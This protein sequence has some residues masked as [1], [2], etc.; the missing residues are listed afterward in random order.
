MSPIQFFFLLYSMV[1][2]LHIHV[3]ILFSH[4]KCSIRSDQTEFPV[5]HSRIPLLIH[6]EGNIL[7]LLN[8]SSQYISL[9]PHHLATMSLFSESM[10]FFSVE[11]FICAVYQIPDMSDTILFFFYSSSPTALCTLFLRSALLTYY[12]WALFCLFVYFF[13]VINCYFPNTFFFYCTAW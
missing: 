6:P 8:P 9:P 5:L 2:Q 10:I 1:T 4:M 7:H 12:S 3:H 11:R 13:I